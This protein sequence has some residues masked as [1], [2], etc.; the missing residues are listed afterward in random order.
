MN[1]LPTIAFGNVVTDPTSKERFEC[2]FMCGTLLGPS[3]DKRSYNLENIQSMLA[4]LQ[5]DPNSSKGFVF[6]VLSSILRSRRGNKQTNESERFACCIHCLNWV[7]RLNSTQSEEPG[8]LQASRHRRKFRIKNT[9]LKGHTNFL[10][11]DTLLICLFNP[12][13]FRS[14]DLRSLLRCCIALTKTV[15]IDGTCYYNAYFYLTP[16]NMRPLLQR[17]VSTHKDSTQGGME[18]FSELHRE[19][20]YEYWL[21]CGKPSFMKHSSITN[22]VRYKVYS[23]EEQKKLL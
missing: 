10:P 17:I 22:A 21:N 11:M 4:G 14:P 7:R 18:K 20:C 3:D 15:E 9:A 2:C 5:I 8:K 6:R 12:S 19:I 13:F 1:Y 23:E 16:E